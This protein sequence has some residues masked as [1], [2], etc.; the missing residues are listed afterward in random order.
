MN[1]PFDEFPED[2]STWETCKR[3]YQF[4]KNRIEV[5]E[6]ALKQCAEQ[7]SKL[8][9]FEAARKALEHEDSEI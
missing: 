9:C 4:L 7:K 2:N 8:P 5:Y 6:E 3:K 1:W